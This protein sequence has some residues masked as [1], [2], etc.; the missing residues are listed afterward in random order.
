MHDSI[1]ELYSDIPD[2]VKLNA[3]LNIPSGMS[4]MELSKKI[5]NIAGKNKVFDSVFRGCG[6]YRHYIPAIVKQV[7]SKEEFVT[8]YTPY[9]AE[10]SQ[11]ILQSIYEYQTMICSLTGMQVANASVYDGAC[12]AAE[13]VIMSKERK[14]KKALV[15]AST[16]PMIIETIATYIRGTD[17]EMEVILQKMVLLI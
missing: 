7:T 4:E 8:A 16:N 3:P 5:T 11:G 1:E 2:E 13:A 9:Q 17:M 14:R 10:I 6:A 15:S 12:A